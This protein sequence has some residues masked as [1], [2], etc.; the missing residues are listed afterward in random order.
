M[1]KNT[2]LLHA[3]TILLF[4]VSGKISQAQI[5][6]SSG[7]TAGSGGQ[8]TA[9]CSTSALDPATGQASAAA[10]DYPYFLAA[11][12]M[13]GSDGPN[14][15]FS[16]C[17]NINITFAPYGNPTGE[18]SMNF[19]P[20][21]GVIYTI[22]S[23]HGLRFYPDPV[24][25]QCGQVPGSICY[26]DPLGYYF[27]DPTNPANPW[28]IM[29]PTYPSTNSVNTVDVPC[30]ARGGVCA[31]QNIPVEYCV[32]GDYLGGNCLGTEIDT[33]AFW[34]IAGS[35]AVFSSLAKNIGN[36]CNIPGSNGTGDPISIC[37]GDVFEEVTDYETVGQN[38]LSY[39]RYYN[40]LSVAG[41]YATDLGSNWR[42]NYDRF[43]Q[44]ISSSLITAERPDGQ[45]INFYNNGGGSWIPDSDVDYTLTQSG[46]T[47]TLTDHNDTTEVYSSNGAGTA[48]LLQSITLRNGYTQT[49]NYT[50]GQLVGVTDSYNRQLAF[51]YS[52]GTISTV[53]TP[54]GLVVTYG[55]NSVINPN[56]QLA[57]VSYS[58]SPVTSQ[59]Y[60]YQNANQ[61]YALTGIQDENGATYKTWTY[62]NFQRGVTSQTGSGANLFTVTYN[63]TN[64]TRTVTNALGVTDTY[65]L[66]YLQNDLKITN[67]SRA[68]TSTTAAVTETFSY[69]SNGYLSGETD[70]NGN[71]TTYVN[72]NHGDPTTINEAVGSSVARTTTIAY[73]PTFVQLPDTIT[74]PGLTTAFTYD[75]SGNVLT[76]TLT[77]TTT[78]STP[79]STNGASR[80][81][82]FTWQNS[83][84][85]SVQSPRTDL[86]EKTTYAYDGTGALTGI[87]NPLNQQTTISSHTGGGLP[88]TIVDPNGVTTNLIYDPRQ[89]LLT[90]TVVTS[91]GNRTTTYG[92]DA[93]E[94][95]TS[96]TRPDGSGLTY[97]YDAAHRLTT[98]TDLL[99]QKISYTLD[100]LGDRTATNILNASSTV[101]REH[102]NTFDALG[103]MLQDIGASSQTSSFTYDA[104]GNMVTA[105]D[106]A[107]NMTQRAFDALNRLY[108][109]TDPA[110]GITTTSYD[111]HDRPLTVT[112]PTG[113]A[114]AYVYDGFGNTIQESNPNTGKTVYYYDGAGNRIQRVAATGAVTLYTYDALDRVLTKTFPSD[115]AENVAYTYDQSGHG[116]GI[117]RLTSVSDAAGT[118]SRS[119]D[120]LG[121]L[122]SEARATSAATLT[123]AYTYDAANRIALITYPSCATVSY[124]RDT[125]GRITAVGTQHGGGTDT[126]AVSNVTYEPFGPYS[127]LTYG[128]GVAE[129]RSYDQDY[130]LTGIADTGTSALQNLAYAYYPTNNV[131]TIT[132][133][134]NSNNSQGFS[135]DSLQRLHQAAG[136]N[137]SFGYTYDGD[138]NQLTQALGATTTSYGYGSG[139]DQFAT[140]SVGGVVTQAIGYTADG[141][142]ASLNPGIQTPNSQYITSLSYNQDARL[143]AV[144]SGSGSLASY[145]Y[146]GFGQRIVK[147]ISGGSAGNI[148]QYGQDGMLLE[149]TNSS[150]AAQADYIYLNGR[151]IATLNKPT[152]ALYFLHD[153]RLGT[154]QLAT[155]SSQNIQ[156]Q[157]SYNPFGQASVSGTVTQNLRFPGQY[158]DVESGWNHNGFRDYLP[159]LGRYAEPDP[160]GRLGSG[161][162]LYV[163]VNDNPT[164]L[165]D[166]LGLCAAPKCS[167]TVPS[168]PTTATLA[169]LIYAEGNG[170]PTGDLAIASVIENRAI[171]GMA[172]FPSSVQG[173][174]AQQT[175]GGNYQF[176]AFGNTLFQSV[177]I[178][179]QVSNLGAANCTSY[180]NAVTAATSAMQPDGIGTN[181]NALYYYDTSIPQP[182]YIT[183]G[184][185]KGTLVPAP[186]AGGTGPNGNSVGGGSG[187]PQLFFTTAP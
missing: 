73:D 43:L 52:N 45:E 11:C 57:S 167:A 33:T 94:N 48:A 68:A 113:V 71:Q 29:P 145:I 10:G 134:V 124:V 24:G 77:D 78:Q 100:A 115:S 123:T 139:S 186:V 2:L 130:R 14:F 105:T 65:T 108:Q 151:P 133:A 35:S 86:V 104:V 25:T 58:T 44:F 66:V 75:G 74:T 42:T 4:F 129:T 161:N 69:D 93:A 20:Q 98:I 101:T 6:V 109:I 128:N 63:D 31:S 76:K 111:A 150:G 53:T 61:P 122:L 157:A 67:V 179:A 79:Y 170:T 126:L 50:N 96:I 41:T 187:S 92:Y 91:G 175:R 80:V 83:L 166:P 26:S 164:N 132:D 168:D 140:I 127:A 149:E 153:D 90:S 32:S 97:T 70:W 39:I 114:T 181:T 103:R 21:P 154:P 131:Q 147:T 72:D 160:L 110:S 9:Y 7:F 85:A 135:Y 162:N 38:K 3:V 55:Y 46:T 171:S 18:C 174:M 148:Y 165:F 36:P 13:T 177:G 176:Q 59:H 82:Q 138:G 117:G 56:D 116:S 49:M 30:S 183:S 22:N 51:T 119:Y 106:Q 28:P 159:A 120:Q 88:L 169:Q 185:N 1:R 27:M 95:L 144:I 136:G 17:P 40:S 143:A 15:T 23:I 99:G 64:L 81:W 54:D 182:G 47:W 16:Q 173:V 125:M 118:L 62:D 34:E 155:D 5:W 137:G 156:W 112:A 172:E 158:Y 184:L 142:I 141:R 178:Q 180:Q 12:S 107:S 8:E 37:S 146:D 89:H 87:T 163:Y 19:T 102:S 60:L 121:N 152:G 84:L